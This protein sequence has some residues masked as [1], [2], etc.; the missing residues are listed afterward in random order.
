M[1]LWFGEDGPGG[2]D[3]VKMQG[4]GNDYVY[5][6]C[7]EQEVRNPQAFARR[8]SGRHYGI[9]SDGVIL[10]K[11]SKRADC[12]MDMYNADGSRGKACGNGLRCVAKLMY[13]KLGRTKKTVSVETLSGVRQCSIEMYSGQKA[14][15]KAQMGPAMLSD[16]RVPLGE[17]YELLPDN[18][19]LAGAQLVDVG[20]PHCVLWLEEKAAA[21]G[22]A[23]FLERLDIE[24][25]GRFLENYQGFAQSVNV[26]FCTG[27]GC[28]MLLCD[29]GC[30][31]PAVRARVW[32]TGTGETLAC[33][34]GACAVFAARRMPEPPAPFGA[35]SSGEGG[36]A[37][38]ESCCIFM[39]GGRLCVE[40]EH[41]SL[42]LSGEAVTVFR[43]II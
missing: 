24:P 8:V 12:F 6:D 3:F 38:W 5:V 28:E 43:G 32:E 35:N 39:P 22:A 14:W 40:W 17:I 31:R 13:E 11:P 33:G 7:F 30:F 19:R 9:G 1:A 26:E 23:E 16:V 10:V 29:D 37:C 25:I 21:Q 20:N 34:S 42:M 15:V 27:M 36:N 41:H 4:A 2:I 18:I